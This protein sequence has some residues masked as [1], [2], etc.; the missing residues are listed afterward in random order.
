MERRRIRHLASGA[1][2]AGSLCV[3]AAVGSVVLI[4]RANHAGD[5]V[6]HLS[7]HLRGGSQGQ[8]VPTARSSATTGGRATSQPATTPTIVAP[9]NEKT[10]ASRTTT[11]PATTTTTRSARVAQPP[12]DDW[13]QTRTGAHRTTTEPVGQ[14]DRAGLGDRDP[15]PLDD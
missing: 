15:A 14:S 13:T 6:G 7:A 2:L 11:T 9:A 5:P 1:L 12:D 8:S 4:G 3:G 10:A